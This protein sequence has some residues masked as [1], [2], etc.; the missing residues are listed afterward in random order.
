M[1]NI[2]SQLIALVHGVLP[3]STEQWAAGDIAIC[4]DTK[5]FAQDEISPKQGEYL[6]V[7]HVCAGGLFLHF[8]GK[9][10]TRHWLAAGFRKLKPDEE[11]PAD[12]AW[13]EELMR[14]RPKVD[15]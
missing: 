13:I 15:A 5:F 9:P 8:T 12:E 2:L 1:S 4:V 6:H 7:T 3:R 10:N 11:S 14:M